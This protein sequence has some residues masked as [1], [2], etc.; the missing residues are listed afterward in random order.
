M[1]NPEINNPYVFEVNA[2]RF[3]ELV[4]MNS[5]KLPVIVEFMGVYSGPSVALENQLNEFAE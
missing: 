4:L 2:K 1:S 3:N 5:Y